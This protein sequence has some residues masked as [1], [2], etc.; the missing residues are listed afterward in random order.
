M[1]QDVPDSSWAVVLFTGQPRSIGDRT[2][3]VGLA[4]QMRMKDERL[5]TLRQ[6]SIVVQHLELVFA[7][8]DINAPGLPLD[9]NGVDASSFRTERSTE[10]C[11]LC[12]FVA[13]V[14]DLD[15]CADF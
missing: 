1:L 2:F 14:P 9:E 3:E 11:D 6:D 12:T 4:C 10:L 7:H 13:G 5:T 15:K 8:L